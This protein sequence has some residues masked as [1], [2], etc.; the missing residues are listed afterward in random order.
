MLLVKLYHLDDSALSG[1]GWKKRRQFIS[2]FLHKIQID[3]AYTEN[4]SPYKIQIYRSIRIRKSTY[5]SDI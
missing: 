1:G 4:N 3:F 5:L 2:D